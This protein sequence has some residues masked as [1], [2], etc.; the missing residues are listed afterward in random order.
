MYSAYREAFGLPSTLGGFLSDLDKKEYFKLLAKT[1]LS[2]RDPEKVVF[3]ELDPLH[4]KTWPDFAVTARRLG[5]AAVDIRSLESTGNKLHYRNA[6]GRLVAI[7]R[8]YNRAIADEL[9][10]R[11]VQLLF[12]MTHAWDVGWA[13]HPNWYFL[14]SKFS[15]PWLSRSPACHPLVPPAVFLHDFLEGDGRGELDA[16]GVPLPSGSGPDAVF[17]ELLLKPLFSFAGKGIQFGPTLA[18]LEAI[19][20]ERRADYLLQQRM[21]F[22]PTIE[23]P[24]GLTQAEIRILYLWPDG[25]R[26]TPVLSLARLGRRKMMGVDHN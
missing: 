18:Q 25:G 9:M 6:T 24:H 8:I 14:I 21:S 2:G 16:A 1:V 20:P 10:A 17:S 15:I 3:T 11:S 19:P 4:Q 12:D 5:I 22:V 13:G 23:T 26:L 7:H